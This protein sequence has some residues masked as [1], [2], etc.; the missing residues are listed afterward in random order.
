MSPRPLVGPRLQRVLALVPYV[1]AHPYVTLAELAERFEISERE[2]E[3]ELALLPMCGLPPYTADRLIDVAVVAGEVTIRLAE[4]FERPLRL[5]PAE[6]LALLAAGRALLAVPGSDPDGPLAH[7]LDKL[8]GTLGARGALAVDVGSGG[9]HLERLTDAVAEHQRVEIDYYSFARDEMTT[10]EVD[11]WRV[12]HAFG[13]WYLAAWCHRAG[14]ERLFRVDRVSGVRPTGEHFEPSVRSDDDIPELVYAPRPDDPR[15]SLELAPSASWV[16]DSYPHESAE[17]RPDGSSLVVLA[18][19]EPAWLERLLL[20]LGPDVTV[21]TP[22]E[23]TDLAA[24]AARR[25]RAR[26]G[27]NSSGPASVPTLRTCEDGVVE[28]HP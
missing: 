13:A 21:V 24:N 22:P 8:E 6:G 28:Q 16:A 20:S 4:Y 7:A 15:V 25:L 11:P 26:Y 23:Y 14:D 3:R 17:T 1:L 2:L 27:D 5:S 18:V 10:R 19:S 9:D 12:F